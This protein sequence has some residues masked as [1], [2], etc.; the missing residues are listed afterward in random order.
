MSDQTPTDS[1]RQ[2]EQQAEHQ[3]EQQA[4]RQNGQ[5]RMGES[6]AAG[7]PKRAMPSRSTSDPEL[8]RRFAV[9]AARTAADNKC[10]DVLLL[11]VR[12]LSQVTDYIVIGSGTSDRQMRST[13]GEVADLGKTMGFGSASISEDTR[14]VWLVADFVD[15]VAHLFEPNT[16][17][18][19]DLEMLWGDAEQVAWAREGGPADRNRAGLKPGEAQ[20]LREASE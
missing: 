13:L 17:A 6:A 11:D 1:E 9:E 2:N 12:G 16:R 14:A 4:E 8:V 18:H 10:E 15:V 3:A 5:R 7:D 20:R 19:Y